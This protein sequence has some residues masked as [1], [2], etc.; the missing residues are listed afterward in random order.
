MLHGVG[1]RTIAEAKERISYEE[2]LWWVAYLNKRGSLNLG[3]RIDGSTAMLAHLVATAAGIKHKSG[4][5]LRMSDF[6]P[7]ADNQGDGEL[8]IEQV[9]AALGGRT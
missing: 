5:A 8:S 4:R 7:H 1:G 2:Y 3:Q 9:F 6:M